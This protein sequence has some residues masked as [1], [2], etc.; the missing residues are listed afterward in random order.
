[1]K[2]KPIETRVEAEVIS[3]K[4]NSQVRQVVQ[5]TT[6]I[7]KRSGVKIP[8]LDIMDGTGSLREE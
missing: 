1:M 8:I 5:T 4:K 2:A 7:Y 3:S 6:G